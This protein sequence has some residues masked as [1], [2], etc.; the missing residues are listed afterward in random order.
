MDCSSTTSQEGHRFRLMDLPGELRSKIYRHALPSI[1]LP[2]WMQGIRSRTNI[3]PR[4]VAI[5]CSAA[6]TLINL[7]LCS[8]QM[9]REVSYVLY[10]QTHFCFSVAPT[11]ASFLDASLLLLWPQTWDIQGKTYI[12]TIQ[13]IVLKA[14]WDGYDCTTI[15]QDSWMNWQDVTSLV[16]E[17]LEK[18][19][20]LRRLTLDWRAPDPDN[21]FQP[22]NVQWISIA[23]CFDKL[24]ATFPD[25]CVEV[26][27]WQ[28]VPGSRPLEHRTIRMPFE[29][30]KTTLKCP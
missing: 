27:A 23:Q 25:L 17:K 28:P 24:K 30:Y 4:P 11:H 1:I 19:R 5:G 7:Q 26:L 8:Q 16:C 13:N 6:R 22:T 3:T 14:N 12:N 9:L 29:E 15:C 10:S 2:R 18:F 20:D 21:V